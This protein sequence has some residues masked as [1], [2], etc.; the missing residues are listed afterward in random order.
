MRYSYMNLSELKNITEHLLPD[1]ELFSHLF[2][3]QF[4][5][6]FVIVCFEVY[7]CEIH[8]MV[9]FKLTSLICL[10][11]CVCFFVFFCFLRAVISAFGLTVLLNT[12]F[13][14]YFMLLSL[15]PVFSNK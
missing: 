14:L 11:V 4:T 1:S 10:H 15:V 9:P 6:P 2:T 8:G 3:L 5:H 13:L 7:L 12:F